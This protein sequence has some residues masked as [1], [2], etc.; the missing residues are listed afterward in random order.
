M[1]HIILHGHIFKNAGTT[2]DWSLQKNFGKNFLDH[3]K[4]LLMRREGRGHIEELLTNE[5]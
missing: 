1:R 4:D 5:Q 3:R 2:F